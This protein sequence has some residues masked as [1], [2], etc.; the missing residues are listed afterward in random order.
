MADKTL[1]VVMGTPGTKCEQ[2]VYSRG[3]NF[4]RPRRCSRTA[5]VVRGD[6]S[7]CRQHDPER[8]KKLKTKDKRERA[9]RQAIQRSIERE[10]LR[11]VKRLGCGHVHASLHGFSRSIVIGFEDVEL[12]LSELQR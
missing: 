11:L 3:L 9:D 7:Y 12:L 5:A 4:P 10:G 6:T 2:T 8:L 1:F